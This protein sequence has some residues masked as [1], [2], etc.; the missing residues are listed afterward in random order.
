MSEPVEIRHAV[1]V[2]IVGAILT[3]ICLASRKSYDASRTHSFPVRPRELIANLAIG[4][5]P[6]SGLALP[7]GLYSSTGLLWQATWLL[8]GFLALLAI[9]SAA[10][11]TLAKLTSKGYFDR[12]VAVFGAGVIARRLYDYASV[13]DHG[14]RFAGLYDDRPAERA[15]P[16]GL[17]VEG[18][19]TDL[20][21]AAHEGRFDK[22]VIAL[23]PAADR[24][25]AMIAEKFDTA[26]VSV[27]LVTHLATDYVE[28]ARAG[29]VSHI[30][31]IGLLDVKTVRS[32]EASAG[33]RVPL[34]DITG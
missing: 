9:H 25:I 34:L 23:P 5:L 7:S 33:A 27:H 1:Q 31:P 10:R 2:S 6:L 4:I 28:D 30:G 21:T 26:P 15:D 12:R 17:T 24:R 13:N 29:D 22:V 3:V 18:R 20:V 11:L 14:F 19:L 32:G 8:T 16:L